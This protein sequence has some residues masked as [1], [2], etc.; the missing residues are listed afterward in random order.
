MN[1]VNLGERK[2]TELDFGRLN[3]LALARSAAQ[4]AQLLEEAEVVDAS[5][6]PDDLVTMYAQVEVEDLPAHR[7]HL[8]VLCDPGQTQPCDGYISVL[9]PVGLA[10]IGLRAGATATWLSPFGERCQARVIA[11]T[12]APAHAH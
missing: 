12:R 8:F 9:S 1:A 4:L 5:Q 10:L 3:Q 11:V 7:R 2:L 6:A